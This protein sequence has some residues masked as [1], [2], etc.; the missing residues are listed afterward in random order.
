MILTIDEKIEEI[1]QQIKVL[2]PTKAKKFEKL[3]VYKNDTNIFLLKISLNLY[4]DIDYNSY[5]EKMLDECGIKRL[6]E[7]DE[8]VLFEIFCDLLDF[9][10]VCE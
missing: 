5:F 9:I 2:F 6:S 8:I 4:D 7:N 3:N 1:K 10:K